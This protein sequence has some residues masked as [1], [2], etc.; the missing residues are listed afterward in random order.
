M[1]LEHPEEDL[2]GA[3]DHLDA[4]SPTG[5]AIVSILEIG[6]GTHS[7]LGFEKIGKCHLPSFGN[8]CALPDTRPVKA[9]GQEVFV[10]EDGAWW[11][12]A[13]LT[14]VDEN[15]LISRHGANLPPINRA[16]FSRA[17]ENAFAAA[18]QK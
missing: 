11:P 7:V 1:T 12:E 4:V 18:L 15:G 9:A 5:R 17:L 13:A 2:A 10:D 6:F 3:V 16:A 14:F 8:D